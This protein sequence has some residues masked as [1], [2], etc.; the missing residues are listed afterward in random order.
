MYNKENVY[1][2]ILKCVG[3]LFIFYLVFIHLLGTYP[4]LDTD[5]T[6]YADIARNMYRSKD[7][8]TMYLDGVIF[9]DKPPLYFWIECLSYKISGVINE[10]SVR[11]P[12]VLCALTQIIALYFSL[13]KFVT[14]DIALKAI[15]IL[16]TSFEFIVF[17]RVAILDMVL[18]TFITLS[19]L[20]GFGT[21]Y[22][23]EK[24]KKYCWWA[25]Y[26][27]SS[28]AVLAKGI[29]GFVV[30][31]GT[32]FFI[33][34]Y[35]R[36]IKEFF[37]PEYFCVGCFLYLLICLPWHI[38]MYHI[39]G[40]K[41]I[42]E[43]I[44]LHHFKRFI[45][46][47]EVDRSEPLLYYIPV[48]L[49][50]FIPWTASFLCSIKKIW[51]NR[52]N[53][54]VMM[55]IIGFVFT[56]VFFT[57][58]KTKLV[59][60]ILPMYFFSAILLAF[61]WSDCKK[62]FKE[63][64]MSAVINYGIFLFLFIGLIFSKLFLSEFIYTVIK[65]VI[66]PLLI[67]FLIF[68]AISFWGIFRHDMMKVFQANIIFVALIFGLLLPK[69]FNVWYD[70]GERDLINIAN[71]AK[72]QNSKLATYC[73]TERFSLQYYYDGEVLYFYS[74]IKPTIKKYVKTKKFKHNTFNGYIVVTSTKKLH[75]LERKM[76]FK[77]LYL[78]KRFS[79]IQQI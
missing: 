38:I 17:S 40:Y 60:Y 20:A 32:M 73:L 50:G 1:L 59:T 46:S 36:N 74:K 63:L 52:S 55:N 78:G 70:F 27:F 47:S 22:V 26:I 67:V 62:Y 48:F 7:Y 6:R 71:I 30:P 25:F 44:I 2:K 75:K 39:H 53:D 3:I 65:P 21:Y 58:S 77:I 34:L 45:G 35:K 10:W 79:L 72:T 5:E 31:F 16:G 4:L 8:I 76:K 57:L 42:D 18:M 12:I 68:L 24:N 33:G 66:V 13:K 23:E 43:Y 56:F 11:L 14:K 61:I 69:I 28:F 51:Q 29:P 15:L 9:W 54:F 41:F 64:Q 49:V 19:I 37:K